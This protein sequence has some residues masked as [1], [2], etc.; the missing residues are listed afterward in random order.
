MMYQFI[1]NSVKKVMRFLVCGNKM[2]FQGN[3]DMP[4]DTPPSGIPFDVLFDK[5][6]HFLVHDLSKFTSVVNFLDTFAQDAFVCF[7]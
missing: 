4:F 1:E 6:S 2:I 3:S 5:F 7:F